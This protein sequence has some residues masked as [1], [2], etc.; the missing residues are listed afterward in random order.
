MRAALF[1]PR[2][3]VAAFAAAK[4]LQ[5]SCCHGRHSVRVSERFHVH[6]EEL[7]VETLRRLCVQWA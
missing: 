1:R 3:F 2:E 4:K 6:S 5:T 7:P